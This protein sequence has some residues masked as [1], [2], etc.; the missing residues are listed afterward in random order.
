MRLQT[1]PILLIDDR[2]SLDWRLLFLPPLTAK[3][4]VRLSFQACHWRLPI[5]NQTCGFRFKLAIGAF[6]SSLLFIS[7]Q[8]SLINPSG[9]DA[10]AKA[11]ASTSFLLFSNSSES[12]SE[13]ALENQMKEEQQSRGQANHTPASAVVL[14]PLERSFRLASN[15]AC[16]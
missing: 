3:S 9:Y 12:E 7:C 13:L 8:P 6:Q 16:N 10:S 11:F 2:S 14:H 5:L 4:D 15:G 1:N